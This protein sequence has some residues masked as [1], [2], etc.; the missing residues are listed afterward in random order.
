MDS[1]QYTEKVRK[2]NLGLYPLYTCESQVWLPCTAAACDEGGI[3]AMDTTEVQAA[4]Y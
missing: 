4:P 2:Q 3:R 1:F